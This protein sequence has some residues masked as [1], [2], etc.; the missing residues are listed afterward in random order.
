MVVTTPIL[1]NTCGIYID[2][3]LLIYLFLLRYGL[4]NDSTVAIEFYFERQSGFFLLQ[5]KNTAV[6]ESKFYFSCLAWLRMI[7]AKARMALAE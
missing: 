7:E 2:F 5:V 4:R 3:F 1:E 6:A